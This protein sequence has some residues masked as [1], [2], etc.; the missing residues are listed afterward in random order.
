M[1]ER[2]GYSLSYFLDEMKRREEGDSEQRQGFSATASLAILKALREADPN[3]LPLTA[4]ARAADLRI[5]PCQEIVETLRQEGL[6]E[7]ELDPTTGND[8]VKLT[9]RGKALS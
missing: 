7:V 8:L 4:L 2:K 9:E 5:G 1:A 3:A 6:V